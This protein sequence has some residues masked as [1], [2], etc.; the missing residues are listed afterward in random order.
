MCPST[1][2]PPPIHPLVGEGPRLPPLACVVNAV[3]MFLAAKRK[4]NP[5]HSFGLITLAEQPTLVVQPTHEV[6]VV[7]AK[8]RGLVPSSKAF[9]PLDLGTL[10]RL[11]SEVSAGTM[12]G[13][14]L[15]LSG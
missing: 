13:C 14:A 10:I 7:K 2:C 3:L 1:V 12:W 5:G 15:G 11:C 4:M 9:G 8:L 6:E